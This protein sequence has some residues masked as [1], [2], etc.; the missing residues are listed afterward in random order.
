[1]ALQT[2]R[3]LVCLTPVRNEAWN[4]ER[5]LLC[6]ETWADVIV[7][8]DQSST[9]GSAEIAQR[10]AKV[11]FVNYPQLTYDDAQRRQ[12]LVELGRA[13]VAEPRVLVALDADEIIADGA[14]QHREMVAFLSRPPGTVAR[15]RWINV[16]PSEPR[17]WIPPAT[18]DFI[19]IDDGRPFRGEAMH[20]PRLPSATA[21]ETLELHGPKVV[22]LQYLD[23]AR[24]RSKQRWYQAQERIENPAKRPIQIYRQYHHMDAIDPTERHPLAAEWYSRYEAELGINLFD[25]QPASVYPTD[26]RIVKLVLEHG[27]ERFRRVDLWDGEWEGRARALGL[28][29]P[30]A[31]MDDP[32]NVLERAIF[33]W[34]ARTQRRSSEPRIRWIQRALRLAGW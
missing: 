11:H 16:L 14:W 25:V 20:G 27:P 24:M 2:G 17:A 7:I 29:A 22:H 12:L 15:M 21:A 32:H 33:R 18:T 1:M 19:F 23:W 5:F 10:H 8:L 31:V 26:E 3:K 4:L 30:A 34:L 13:A 9:D 28:P 6:A